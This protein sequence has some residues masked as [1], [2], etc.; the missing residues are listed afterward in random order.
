MKAKTENRDWS[1]IGLRSDFPCFLQT[2]AIYCVLPMGLCLDLQLGKGAACEFCHLCEEGVLKVRT[3][4]R[5]FVS[6]ATATSI[7]NPHEGDNSQGNIIT[8]LG[9][10]LT[11]TG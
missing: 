9:P 1:E 11:P 2:F 5:K 6:V 7:G 8:L 3:Q 4:E 10:Y